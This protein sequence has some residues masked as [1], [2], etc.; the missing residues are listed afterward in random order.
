MLTVRTATTEDLDRI[1]KIY[2]RARG[3]MRDHGNPRQWGDNWPPKE[4]IE[5]DIRQKKMRVVEADGQV[6][7]AFF[8]DVCDDP[9]YRMIDKGKWLDDSPYGVI[10]RIASAGIAKRVGRAAIDWASDQCPHL[11]IDTHA[12]N[13]VMQNM[14]KQNGF[15]YCGIIYVRE[16][17][18]PRL[19]YEKTGG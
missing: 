17:S 9:S 13:L 18:D 3:F 15:R 19:A 7:G 14:L 1:L 8:F 10:H 6:A 5:D 2:E 12:D 11:R 4:L 16:D